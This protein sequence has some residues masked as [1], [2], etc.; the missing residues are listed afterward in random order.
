MDEYNFEEEIQIHTE[1]G[2]HFEQDVKKHSELQG[3]YA[4]LAAQAEKA[5][6]IL[7]LKIEMMTARIISEIVATEKIAVSYIQHLKKT[8]VPLDKRYIDLKRQWIDALETS[9]TLNGYSFAW[10]S[11]G[12]NL[13]KLGYIMSGKATD[14]DFTVGGK[15]ANTKLKET[16]G[17]IEG[18][19]DADN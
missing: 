5:V 2:W 19:E 6:Q 3:K 15:R 12:K 16:E 13:E 7:E 9:K 4:K 1:S 18:W 11:R 14:N 17:K 10:T 8:R